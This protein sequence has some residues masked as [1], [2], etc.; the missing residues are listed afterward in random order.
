V[1]LAYETF[2]EPLQADARDVLCREAAWLPVALGAREADVPQDGEA[3]SAYLIRL[4]SAGALAVGPDARDLA[5]ALL[6]PAGLDLA[7]PL[8]GLNRLFAIGTLP[9]HVRS[10][11]GFEWTPRHAAR[12]SRATRFVRRIRPAVP[13]ALA[14]WQDARR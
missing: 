4:Y 6:R 2:V 14:L 12:L 3:L 1:T 10:L 5:A 8:T 7:W 9:D 13:R 11:Y